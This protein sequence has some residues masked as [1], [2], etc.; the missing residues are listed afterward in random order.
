[1]RTGFVIALSIYKRPRP[2]W[3]RWARHIEKQFDPLSSEELDMSVGHLLNLRDRMDTLPGRLQNSIPW[4]SA[5]SFSD[6]LWLAEML[7]QTDLRLTQRYN[8]P[9][10][11]ACDTPQVMAALLVVEAWLQLVPRG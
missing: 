6:N 4:E 1:V 8:F 7:Q 3:Y 9:D 10:I 2:D 11:P 5:S